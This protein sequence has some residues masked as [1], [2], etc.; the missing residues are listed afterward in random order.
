MTEIGRSAGWRDRVFSTYFVFLA[1]VYPCL[2]APSPALKEMPVQKLT[3]PND[4]AIILEKDE[5]SAV[6]VIQILV[7][8]GSRSEP[9][10][11]EGLSF[12]TSRL[13]VEIP[14]SAKAQSLMRMAALFWATAG[15]DH[16]LIKIQ[17]LS[18]HLE[19]TLEIASRILLAPLFSG[20]RVENIKKAML[21]QAT[22]EMDD[23]VRAGHRAHW[24]A[25]YGNSGYGRR[26]YGREETL[27]AVKAKDASS[28]Y[29]TH[30]RAGNI[31]LCASSDMNPESLLPLLVK[32]FSKVPRGGPAGLAPLSAAIPE[33]RAIFI[34]KQ[35][36]QT[37]IS[38]AFHLPRISPKNIVI[39]YVLDDILGDRPGSRLWP[40]RTEK[41]L[42]YNVNCRVTQFEEGGLLEA[43][44]ETDKE[45]VSIARESLRRI[46]GELYENGV[47]AEEFL[48]AKSGAKTRFLRWNET[49][50]VRTATLAAF[51]SWGLGYDFLGGF[52]RELEALTLEELNDYISKT[53]DQERGV[54]VLIGPEVTEQP[55]CL[56]PPSLY[57]HPLEW[58]RLS[59]RSLP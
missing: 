9:E 53:L 6:T 45:K 46:L 17:C 23:A 42:A 55:A 31:I 41:K 4:L 43:Y 26:P 24:Q 1:A 7:K 57:P 54:E 21:H 15:G 8:G 59:K 28:F 3:L 34:P 38:T 20:I 44:L 22:L 49:K 36:K 48:T 5:S 2:A 14:D 10:G 32:T 40:L 19:K 39:G 12:L 37:Y 51:E 33:K 52:F 18:L 50:D 58:L 25:F 16:S 47:A 30:F 29:D 27:R 56:I 35:T 11:K 13:A